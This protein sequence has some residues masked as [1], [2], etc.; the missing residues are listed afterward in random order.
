MQTTAALRHRLLAAVVAFLVL[1]VAGAEPADKGPDKGPAAF[2]HLSYRS[3]GPAAGGRV[4]RVCGV[5]GN[6]LIYYAAT[7]SGG[8]WKSSSKASMV[9]E[10]APSSNSAKKPPWRD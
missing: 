1:S 3:L 6:P 9:V 5:S 4:C 10:L 7:A 8:V 2:K